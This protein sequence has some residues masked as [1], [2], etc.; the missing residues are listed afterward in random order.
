VSGRDSSTNAL[1]PPEKRS[2]L[3]LFLAP[4]G[5]RP[6]WV[7][8]AVF[9][10]TFLAGGTAILVAGLFGFSGG[11]RSAPVPIVPIGVALMSL[12]AVLILG[13]YLVRRKLPR[14]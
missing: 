11:P 13:S 3:E 5:T 2:W 12:G 14:V 7:D 9:G 4:R 10:V 6:I 8:L 1:G